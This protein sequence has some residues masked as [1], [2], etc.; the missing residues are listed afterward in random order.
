MFS[1]FYIKFSGKE[2]VKKLSCEENGHWNVKYNKVY[3]G[4]TWRDFYNIVRRIIICL[5]EIFI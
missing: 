3:S 1:V 2:E 5:V 4:I